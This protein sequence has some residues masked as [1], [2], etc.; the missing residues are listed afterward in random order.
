MDYFHFANF[1]V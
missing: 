1:P